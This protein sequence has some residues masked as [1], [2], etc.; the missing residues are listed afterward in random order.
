LFDDTGKQL[1]AEALYLY[2]VMLL[3]LDQRIEGIVRERMLISALRYIGQNEL[4]TIDEV[5]RMEA[6]PTYIV[7]S[8]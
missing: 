7:A 1:M 5:H 8:T 4:P 2:G 3:L 6:S